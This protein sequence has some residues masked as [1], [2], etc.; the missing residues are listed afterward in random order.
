MRNRFATMFLLNVHIIIVVAADC[1]ACMRRRIRR[2]K[3]GKRATVEASEGKAEQEKRSGSRGSHS[4]LNQHTRQ[5]SQ[6]FRVSE[7]ESHKELGSGA[8]VAS[9]LASSE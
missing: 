4:F 7:R 1:S 9:R 3:R 5:C 6:C 8:S 2:G